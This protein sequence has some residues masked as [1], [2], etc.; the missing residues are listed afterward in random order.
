MK[1]V[2]CGHIESKVLDSRTVGEGNSIRRR[3]E[4]LNCG[5]RFTTYEVIETAPILVIK[6]D[7]TR[8]PFDP[9]KIKT[10]IIKACEKRPV[11][12]S[13]IDKLV[14]GIEKYVLNS[15]EQEIPSARLGELVMKGL[16]ELDQVA[17]IR[18]ASVYRQFRDVTTFI[19]F[20]NGFEKMIKDD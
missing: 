9:M 1:C 16:K 11:P 4:C 12:M 13:E 19:D 17:Y 2:Y 18:F 5:R 8:Q 14:N 7:G 6:N 10:G 3:R 15:L 20:I